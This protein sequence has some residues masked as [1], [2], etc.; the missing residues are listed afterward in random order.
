MSLMERVE[1]AGNAQAHPASRRD[2]GGLA[3]LRRQVQALIAVDDIAAIAA[4]NPERARN[5][6]RAACR[7]AFEEPVWALAAPALRQ[8]LTDELLD[9]L[10]GFGL[11]EDLLA[12]DTVTEIMVNGSRSLYFEREGK[13]VRC[14]GS[15][16]TDEEVR[17]LID[18]M[19]GPLGRRHPLP[20]HQVDLF[21][22]DPRR[23]V[24]DVEERLV[25]SVQVAHKVLGALG[26]P[27]DGFDADDLAGGRRHGGE[28]PGQHPQIAQVFLVVWK[29][30]SPSS[31][32]RWLVFTLHL[33]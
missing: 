26:Q 31:H 20:Q 30:G 18:R 29:H 5:E 12:D 11:L 15:F 25:L 19:L 22:D 2:G 4:E 14:P 8:R 27:G 1:A 3:L 10:F 32:L 28:L 6:V 17:T 13:L 24:E 7:Q 21:P 33:L 23:T 16:K 9:A